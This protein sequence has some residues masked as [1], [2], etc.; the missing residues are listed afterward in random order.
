MRE[1][2]AQLLANRGPQVSRDPHNPHTEAAMA[3]VS[4][5]LLIGGGLRQAM[6]ILQTDMQVLNTLPHRFGGGCMWD[7]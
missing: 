7:I 4:H 3:H 1:Q 2:E 6:I 5:S